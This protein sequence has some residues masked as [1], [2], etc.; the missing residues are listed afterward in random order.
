MRPRCRQG[1]RQR[2]PVA[3]SVAHPRRCRA[4][5]RTFVETLV[6]IDMWTEPRSGVTAVPAPAPPHLA[7]AP[8][9][10][11]TARSTA[12]GR[13]SAPAETNR[14]IDATSRRTE[15]PAMATAPRLTTAVLP[16][17]GR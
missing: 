8:A 1:R 7:R 11:V 3:R 6:N 12:G 10:A 9:S 14:L 2:A 5:A 17:V 15:A 4:T 13:A 16:A